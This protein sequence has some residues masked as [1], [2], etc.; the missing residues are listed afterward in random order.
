MFVW[1]IAGGLSTISISLMAAQSGSATNLA[2]LGPS[3]LVRALVAAVIAG[4]VSFP[5]AFFAGVAIGVLQAL[6]GFNFIDQPGLIDFLL[7]VGVLVAVYFQSRNAPRETQTFSF[8]PEAATDPRRS[9][10]DRWWVRQLD[11][12]GL[13]VLAVAAVILPLVVTQPSR[14]LLYTTIL[15]FALCGMSLTS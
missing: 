13:V 10:R 11:R 5:R 4:M 6:I 3:T 2:T 15:V 7:L 14:H 9:S 1:A 12:I 8:A